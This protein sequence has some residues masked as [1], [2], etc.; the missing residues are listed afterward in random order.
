MVGFIKIDYFLY[1]LF[2]ETI[3]GLSRAGAIG[4][5]GRLSTCD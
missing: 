4:A 2:S 3:F 1:F 5:I